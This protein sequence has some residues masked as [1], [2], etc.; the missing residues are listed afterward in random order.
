VGPLQWLQQHPPEHGRD[1]QVFLLTDGQVSNL[2]EV[3]ELCRSLASSTRIFSF[4][5]GAAPSRS[6]VKGL[7]RITNGQFVFI[8]PDTSIE[9]YIGGKLQKTNGC[10]V[11]EVRVEWNLGAPVENV[12]SQ[13]PSVHP[14]DRA[15]FYALA[16]NTPILLTT[17]S[18]VEIQTDQSYYRLSI[19][20]SDRIT[21]SNQMIER[22]AAKALILQMEHSHVPQIGPKKV[23]FEQMGE[24]DADDSISEVITRTKQQRKQRIIDLSLRYNILSSYTTFIGIEKRYADR[25]VDTVRREIPIEIFISDQRSRSRHAVNVENGAEYSDASECTSATTTNRFHHARD[26][27]S[28]TREFHTS[29][30]ETNPMI[31]AKNTV[32]FLLQKQAADGLWYFVSNSKVIEDLTGKPLA[33]FQTSETHSSVPLLVT[34][35]IIILLESKFSALCSMWEEMVDRARQRL[36]DLLNND[37]KSL[38]TL[39]RNIRMTLTK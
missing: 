36:I 16:G 14:D 1:R 22:L 35:I 10:C 18:S 31:D 4:G 25:D 29:E 12:P 27:S 30:D 24:D 28:Q 20:G 9:A 3:F 34:A 32:Y 13:L 21:N 33:A 23:R 38:I 2:S 26:Y 11:T 37:W 8:P 15:I 7:A 19:T 6:L 39:F 5:L 17:Q